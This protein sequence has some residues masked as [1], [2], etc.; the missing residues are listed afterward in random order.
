MQSSH[1]PTAAVVLPGTGS[2][3]HFVGRVFTGPL[4]E[5][6]VE[7][8]AVEPDPRRVVGS[9]LDAL[10]DAASRHGRI[11]VGGVSIGAA[12]ALR[13][14][15]DNPTKAVGVLAALPPWTGSSADAPA[16][17]SARFTAERLRA[18]GLDAV[19]RTMI[20]SSPSWLGRE[21]EQ[22]WRAQW[23]HL[24]EALDEAAAYQALSEEEL[25]RITVPVG[26]AAATDDAVHPLTV[27]E[28]W[29]RRLP[30]AQLTTVGLDD[31]GYDAAVLGRAC[32]RGLDA[33]WPR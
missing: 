10:D 1:W 22:S 31:I 18:D 12:V 32:V 4:A 7:T 16:A 27:A 19:T 23:P 13:W 2:G 26:I 24:P 3:A 21:L 8:H 17:A 9:Y 33:A 6:G 28:N 30:R 14:A 25:E 5:R 11:I 20:E 29:A 15:A